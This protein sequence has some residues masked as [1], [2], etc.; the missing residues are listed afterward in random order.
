[1]SKLNS[2][3]I[4]ISN[5]DNRTIIQYADDDQNGSSIANDDGSGDDYSINFLNNGL[6]FG[7]NWTDITASNH[8]GCGLGDG[9]GNENGGCLKGGDYEDE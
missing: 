6:G 4:R 1:M 2:L 3:F 7:C 8:S 5:Y 9:Y